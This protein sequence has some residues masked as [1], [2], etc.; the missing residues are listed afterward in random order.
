VHRID[1][2]SFRDHL[3]GPLGVSKSAHIQID[4]YSLLAIGTVLQGGGRSAF[5][6]LIACSTP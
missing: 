2:F 6:G 5:V 1:L 3:S 4:S